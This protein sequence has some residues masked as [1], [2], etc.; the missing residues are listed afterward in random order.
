M[1]QN[2]AIKMDETN[3]HK[4]VIATIPITKENSQNGEFKVYP[5]FAFKVALS[6]FMINQ[7]GGIKTGNLQETEANEIQ[8][9]RSFHNHDT[10]LISPNHPGF[11]V[12]LFGSEEN[13]KLFSAKHVG[14]CNLD[15]L[16]SWLNS[17]ENE[18]VDLEWGFFDVYNDGD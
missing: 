11:Y 10:A 8:L 15:A 5:A 14:G 7:S 3:R 6:K 13:S 1:I 9:N 2:S 4:K 18:I 16:I 12:V 17:P